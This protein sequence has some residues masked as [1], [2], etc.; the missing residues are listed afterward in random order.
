[1]RKR[2][3][4]KG[5]IY[6]LS[7]RRTNPWAVR[8]TIGKNEKGYPI[9]KFIG[10]YHTYEEANRVLHEY[11]KSPYSLNDETLNDMYERFIVGYEETHKPKTVEGFKA[12]W[13][14]LSP[15]Y[16]EP[17]ANLTRKK[18]Q[19]FFDNLDASQIVKTKVKTTLKAVLSY[20]VRYDVI[21]PERMVILDYIDLTSHVVNKGVEHKVFT[22][23]EIKRIK[24]INDD[25]SKVILFLIYTGLRAGEF[26]S[27]SDNSIDEDMVIHI[28]DSKTEAGIRD[29]PLSNKA[30]K[31]SPVPQF[32][33]YSTLYYQFHKWQ[34]KY[35][36]DHEL[37]DTRHTCISLL[38]EAKIDERIIRSI[39]GHKGTGVT[40]NV[41]T[42][43]GIEAKREALNKI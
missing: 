40:E 11:N 35:K 17:I 9:Y 39:V 4:G 16:E 24:K 1:M 29:V 18:L 5:S 8:K 19:L 36:F 3:N 22:K 33:S 27:I 21:P 15:L 20:S 14:H 37:H 13:K 12:K 43:I 38:T 23:E 28:E 30:Q 32:K 42:H 10:F 25:I 6:K 41:Y 26:C 7:G 34:K 31:L 2:A